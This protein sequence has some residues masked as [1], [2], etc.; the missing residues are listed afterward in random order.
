MFCF[1]FFSFS[2]IVNMFRVAVLCFEGRGLERDRSHSL[3]HLYAF[4]R[5]TTYNWFSFSPVSTN[6]L[7]VRCKKYCPQKRLHPTKLV[8]FNMQHSV[9]VWW[10]NHYGGS[11]CR[12]PMYVYH[13]HVPIV[14]HPCITITMFKRIKSHPHHVPNES[15]SH[16]L[17][18]CL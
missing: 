4:R 10:H 3:Y 7:P 17:N 2:S 15:I 5:C 12:A 11:Y 8:L 13:Y 9:M 14:G 6:P 16:S 1:F 18:V